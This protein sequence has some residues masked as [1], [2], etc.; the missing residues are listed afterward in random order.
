MDKIP[1]SLVNDL[2]NVITIFKESGP[3]NLTFINDKGL[4]DK[5]KA[6][7]IDSY[8][9]FFENY[10]KSITFSQKNI[11]HLMNTYAI[12]AHDIYVL[13]EFFLAFFSWRIFSDIVLGKKDIFLKGGQQKVDLIK[14]LNNFFSKIIN[15]GKFMHLNVFRLLQSEFTN[16]P[17]DIKKIINQTFKDTLKFKLKQIALISQYE[18]WSISA[19]FL[20]GESGSFYVISEGFYCFNEGEEVSNII[21]PS[22]NGFHIIFTDNKFYNQKEYVKE[23]FSDSDI[24]FITSQSDFFIYYGNWVIMMS[25]LITLSKNSVQDKE[26]YNPYIKTLFE[27]IIVLHSVKKESLEDVWDVKPSLLTAI[28]KFKIHV[29]DIYFSNTLDKDIK[30]YILNLVEFS[31]Q[32]DAIDNEEIN[33]NETY[34]EIKLQ[35]LNI[36]MNIIKNSLTNFINNITRKIL[37]NNNKIQNDQMLIEMVHTQLDKDKLEVQNKDLQLRNAEIEKEKLELQA[38]ITAQLQQAHQS[39]GERN[40]HSAAQQQQIIQLQSEKAQLETSIATQQQQII[41]LQSD[42]S[43]LETSIQ[44]KTV[45]LNELESEKVVLKSSV[46]QL[47]QAVSESQSMMTLMKRRLIQTST[48]QNKIN[49]NDEEVFS[50]KNEFNKKRIKIIED[51]KKMQIDGTE[52]TKNT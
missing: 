20:K 4:N 15:D 33:V 42:K 48:I 9:K 38:S 49:M 14:I 37:I 23:L 50:L 7:S 13:S 25:I 27:H 52:E 2:T 18:L 26:S 6:L 16:D 31:N 40:I 3:V 47:T 17:F 11:E 43:Q 29:F 32:S 24:N 28:I 1:G 30:Q 19:Y 12:Q 5:D 21:F 8:P 46:A 36:Q 51:Q 22:I 34:L 10:P 35:I 44:E 45:Q 41:Q 39:E